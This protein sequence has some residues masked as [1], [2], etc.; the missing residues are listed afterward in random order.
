M[1]K[2]SEK[3]GILSLSDYG[4]DEVAFTYIRKSNSFDSIQKVDMTNML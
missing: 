2:N 1:N 4:K 3:E